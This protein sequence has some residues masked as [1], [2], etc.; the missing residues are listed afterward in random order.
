ML[1]FAIR[2]TQPTYHLDP[3][4]NR[5]NTAQQI[6]THYMHDYLQDLG[7]IFFRTFHGQRK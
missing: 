7:I 2:S 1:G 5:T 6:V 3:A 4:S